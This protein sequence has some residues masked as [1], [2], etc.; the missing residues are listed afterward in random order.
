MSA[1]VWSDSFIVGHAEVDEDHR[2]LFDAI[3]DLLG[4]A[5]TQVP[6]DVLGER[7]DA[8]LEDFIQHN[9][10]EEALMESL[11]EPASVNHRAHHLKGHAEFISRT[12]ATR[13]QLDAGVDCRMEI[14]RLAMF[15]TLMELVRDDFDMIGCLC[16]EGLIRPDSAHSD[17]RLL[18][19]L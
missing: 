10:M 6:A 14:E 2:R 5:E 13:E 17:A 11:R 19:T 9:A 1:L 8:I 12:R 18:T 4:M 16:H 15:L 7:L 3:I